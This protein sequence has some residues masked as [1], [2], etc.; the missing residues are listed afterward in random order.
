M[1]ISEILKKQ[2]FFSG[3]SQNNI[4]LISESATIKHVKKDNYVF[5]V[6]E[7]AR[8]FYLILKGKV[9]LEVEH[10]NKIFDL[11]IINEGEIL[12]WSW[13]FPPYKW[14]FSAKAIEDLELIEFDVDIFYQK[15]NINIKNNVKKTTIYKKKTYRNI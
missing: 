14:N 15:C 12:G 9:S 6:G 1:E 10:E 13:Q 11:E 8:K 5:K 3:I 7:N 2:D 4:N